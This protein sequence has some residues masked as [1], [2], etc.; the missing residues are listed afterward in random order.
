[1]GADS[2][3]YKIAPD[4]VAALAKPRL[5]FVAV[6]L[7]G[8]SPFDAKT[9][10][11]TR[12]ADIVELKKTTEAAVA[13]MRW[14]YVQPAANKDASADTETTVKIL[15]TLGSYQPFKILSDTASPDDLKKWGLDAPRGK[16]TVGLAGN[17]KPREFLF[18]SEADDK[19]TVYLKLADRPFVMLAR[20]AM[21][22]ELALADF[23]D[24]V[25]FRTDPA[26]VRTIVLNGWKAPPTNI[27]KQVTLELNEGKWISNTPDFAVDEAKIKVFLNALRAPRLTEFVKELKAAEMGLGTENGSMQIFL[28]Q[29]GVP[30][31]VWLDLGKEEPGKPGSIYATSSSVKGTVF[32]IDGT[33][34]KLFVLDAKALQK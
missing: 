34:F 20:K 11:L 24:K 5:E 32:K 3:E 26:K 10:T 6:Q 25:I 16:V 17:E 22:E 7:T 15:S 23:R 13:D 31:P 2:T 28:H 21:F 12:G 1:M 30:E 18:G 9:L 27:A 4:L 8:F 19:T 29:E 14:A 33:Y